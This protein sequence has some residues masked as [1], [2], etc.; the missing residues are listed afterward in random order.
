MKEKIKELQAGLPQGVTIRPVYDRSELIMRAIDTLK[1]KL[2]EEFIVVSLVC[3][4]FLL[5]FRSSLVAIVMLPVGIL[6]SFI[7]MYAMGISAN[8][9]SLGRDCHSHRRYDRRR[10]SDDRER[11]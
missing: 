6:I 1:E 9:M 11:A 3:I 10:H 7:V 5:H 8:I 4:I 2:V